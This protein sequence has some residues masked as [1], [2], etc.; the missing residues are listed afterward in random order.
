MY[1]IHPYLNVLLHSFNKADYKKFLLTIFL[2][3]SIIPTFTKSHFESSNLINFICLYSLAG[4]FRLWA[5]D[6][7]DKK[8]IFYGSIFITINFMSTILFDLLGLKFPIFG[9][10]AAYFYDMMRPFT[11]LAASSL[12]LGFRKLDVKYNKL[13]N[14][15]AS[16][17]FGIYLI[18]DNY[19]T[20]PFLWHTVF[21]NA[22]F[23]ESSYLIPYSIAVIFIV[24][25][26]CTLIELLCSKIF[27]TIS[28]GIKAC[29]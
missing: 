1:L 2:Y 3:W 12:L 25:I 6:F 29:Q 26:L 18:H 20:R 10:G 15:L 11:I 4:Y 23:Q 7:G 17:T 16:A 27:K 28:F 9:K 21:K 14:K 8:Y 19:L 24:Y 13:I 22:S 5:K